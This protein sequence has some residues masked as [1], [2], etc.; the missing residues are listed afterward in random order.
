VCVCVCVC[1]LVCV[2]VCVG[3]LEFGTDIKKK[4]YGRHQHDEVNN[5][6]H[7]VS[8]PVESVLLVFEEKSRPRPRSPS[9]NLK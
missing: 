2:C 5:E 9:F 4:R 3:L 7:D 8:V 6:L 1:V